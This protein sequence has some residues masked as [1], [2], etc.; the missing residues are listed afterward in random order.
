LC[1]ALALG[2]GGGKS[3]DPGDAAADA[4]AD[5]GEDPVVDTVADPDAEETTGDP[6][7]DPAEEDVPDP[8]PAAVLTY[9][10]RYEHQD[11]GPDHILGAALF[12]AD[13]LLVTSANGVAVVERA[14]VEAGTVTA[15]VGKYMT[16]TSATSNLDGAPTGSHYFPRFFSAAVSGSTAYVTT[17]Y[18]GLYVFDV[19]GTGTSWSVA[20][21]DVHLRSREFTEGVDVVG[22]RLYLA[23]HADGIEVM[24]IGADP[25]APATVDTLADP[26]VD[27]WGISADAD[28]KVW[29]AD[30]AGGVKLARLISGE[31]SFITG[32]TVTTSPGTA[33]DVAVQGDWVVAAMGGQGI[34]VYEEWTAS[35]RNTYELPG[36]CVDVEPMGEDRF[37]VACREWVHVVDV[38]AL[39]I[40]R[41]AASARLHR[42]LDGGGAGV[43]VASRVTAAGDVLF[44]SGWDHLDAYRIDTEG[45]APDIQLSGQRAHFG[46]PPGF[47]AFDVR[48]AG[49]GTLTI[50]SLQCDEASL[51]C[52]VDSSTVAPGES[53][54]LRI[55][56]DGSGTNVE[57]VVRVHSDDPD[58]PVLPVFVF[59]ALDDFVDPL[60]TAPDFTAD[61]SLHDPDA[62]T[63]TDGSLTL[64][65]F[66]TAGEVVHLFVFGTWS[67]ASLPE[68][69]AL[70]GDIHA[71]LPA[72]AEALL[73]DQGEP[74]ATV[75][76][77]IEKTYLPLTVAHDEDGTIGGDLYDQPATGL[78]F[79]R[80]YVVDSESI[81]TRVG[82]SYEPAA[83]LEAVEEAL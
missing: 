39:G 78:P 67:P 82:A 47:R 59:V 71:A 29:V 58:E 22:D 79:G 12:G 50:D 25:Q 18:D 16:D 57:S 41:V 37:A 10:G 15:H 43:H 32:D 52:E 80:S 8:G 42:R 6:L 4:P 45:T 49:F 38:T 51:S 31:L 3:G 66:D 77:V 68:V 55:V 54:V 61:T 28:G 1:A 74:V 5:E 60:S 73:L 9:L 2:C 40:A 83:V 20:L 13:H 24:D 26:F 75:R 21:A 36:V 23:H 56:S 14:A 33:L 62:G 7:E 63:F 65:D 11:D 69:A 44:V 81:V 70:H 64:S 17:R 76:H 48:N 53:T 35:Q 34:A 27:A 72:G 46:D 30:G 19:G